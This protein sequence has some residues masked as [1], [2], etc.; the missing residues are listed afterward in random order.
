MGGCTNLKRFAGRASVTFTLL[1]SLAMAAAPAHAT[2]I[3]DTLI[4]SANLPNSGDATEMQ[5]L[6][7]I[8]GVNVNTLTL[9]QK[10]DTPNGFPAALNPGTL[11]QWFIDVA[12]D[13]P[14]FFMLKFG[15]GGTG[16]LNEHFFFKNVG[17]LTKLVWSNSQVE[18]LSGGACG[19]SNNNAC[20]IGRLSHYVT[21]NGDEGGGSTGGPLPEPASVAL[22]ALGLAGLAALRRNRR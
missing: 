4:G 3:V 1:G 19:A 2:Y 5:A 15:I 20:N 21:V 14:G 22:F 6:A 16:A 18:F 12:P 10:I 8:L 9:D 7:T 11:D 13:T 17:E